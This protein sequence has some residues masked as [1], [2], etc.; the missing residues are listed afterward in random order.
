MKVSDAGVFNRV[1]DAKPEFHY[2]LFKS[3]HKSSYDDQGLEILGECRTKA[4]AGWLKSLAGRVT[5]AWWK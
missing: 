4:N 5:S 1:R 3:E 2:Q